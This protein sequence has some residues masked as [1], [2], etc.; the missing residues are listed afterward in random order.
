M[1]NSSGTTI[2][3]SYTFS[4]Q[5]WREQF[6]RV[7]LTGA[8]LFGALAVG[9]SFLSPTEFIF[10]LIYSAAYII[11]LLVT[12]VRL[13]YWL[14]AGTLLLLVYALGLSG[15]FETG[16]WGDSRVFFLALVIITGLLL[17]PRAATLS[18]ILTTISTTTVGWLLFSG[19]LQLA[20]TSVTLGSTGDWVSG[21]VSSIM[22]GAVIV[23]GL[24]LFQREFNRA[25]QRSNEALSVLQNERANLEAFVTQ[26]TEELRRKTTQLQ[27][28]SLVARR[29][30]EIRDLPTLLNNIV[31]LITEQFGFY[32]T[33][34]FL[35][36]ENRRFAVLQA[37]SS[38]GGRKM[39][40]AGHRLQLGVQGIVGYVAA[41]GRPRIAL[42]VGADSVFFNNP[43][44]PFTRSEMALP[45]TVREQ[46]IGVLDIQSDQP[47]A[48][49]PDDVE[50]LQTLA[51][52]LAVAIENAR[53]FSES[54]AIIAQLEALTMIQTRQ[55]WEK[56][57]ARRR[58]AYQYTPLGIKPVTTEEPTPLAGKTLEI[59]LQLRG[60][61]IGTITLSR[62]ESAPNWTSRDRELATEIANQIA[63]AVDNSRLLE[64]I[65]RGAARDQLVANV[66]S[67]IRETLDLETVL[68]IA[69]VEFQK[70]FGLKEAEILLKPQP[71][72]RTTEG[73]QRNTPNGRD[74]A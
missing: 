23:I 57:I 62:S 16:I 8:S 45:L 28:A 54:Q 47:Q 50:I 67:R 44:L 34:I 20:T 26:R 27:T 1:S 52:Q 42:D 64:E 46:I 38:D 66:S 55:A 37:A 19:Q 63:L 48:F 56:F 60:Q 11:L 7:L 17:S 14:R 61:V 65:Q 31:H 35:I 30:A 22:L 24:N 6:V 59:P 33:G 49:S 9:A 2:S 32:H 18:I 10:R 40:E 36:D 69:A 53:L 4:F 68:Q 58:L 25:Q 39:L 29:V 5:Q 21:T 74:P 13:P 15:L 51:D 43:Y 41:Q 12:F 72:V 3:D 70:A 71:P 73:Q